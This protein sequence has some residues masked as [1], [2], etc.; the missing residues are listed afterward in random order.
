MMG[1]SET[2]AD[3]IIIR[4]AY[5]ASEYHLN[6]QQKLKILTLKLKIT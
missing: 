3:I 6:Q 1:Y 4:N 2:V 5:C